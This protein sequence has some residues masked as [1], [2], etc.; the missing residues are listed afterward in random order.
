MTDLAIFDAERHKL[1]RRHSKALHMIARYSDDA[2]TIAAL[3]DHIIVTRL[4]AEFHNPGEK[5]P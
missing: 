4:H 5:T 2:A 3:I 1:I